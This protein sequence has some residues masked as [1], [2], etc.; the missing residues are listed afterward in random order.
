MTQRDESIIDIGQ[1]RR[2]RMRWEALRRVSMI[3]AE[4]HIT[5]RRRLELWREAA[6]VGCTQ[7]EIAIAAGV[8][9]A[10]VGD[11]L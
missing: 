2:Q 6:G 8:S 10:T 11:E 4:Y 7:A 9:S 5:R 1:H 3:E